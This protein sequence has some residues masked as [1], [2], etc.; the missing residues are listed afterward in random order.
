MSE[1]HPTPEKLRR[2]IVRAFHDEGLSYAQIAHLLGIGEATV[3]RVLRLYRETGDVVPRPKGGGRLSPIRGKVASE[4]KRLVAQK[5][6]AT[7]RELM[8]ELTARTGIITSRPSMQRAL[9]RLGFSHKKSP[10]P[11]ASATRRKTSGA[12]VS[13]PHS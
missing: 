4:L 7:V 1:G 11:P 9:H 10:S 6:D 2:A 8:A 12:G 3:S 13:S 5:P